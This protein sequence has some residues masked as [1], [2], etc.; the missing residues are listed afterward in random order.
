[1]PSRNRQ[2]IGNQ[3]TPMRRQVPLL[4]L[5]FLHILHLHIPLLA[6]SPTYSTPTTTYIPQ[7]NTASDPLPTTFSL[8][9]NTHTPFQYS[10]LTLPSLTLP[11]ITI[12]NFSSLFSLPS[13]TV[14]SLT[15]PTFSAIALPTNDA[16]GGGV[17]GAGGGG[18]D[19]AGSGDNF[20]GDSATA[21]AAVATAGQNI[22]QASGAERLGG[23][24]PWKGM[25]IGLVG[26]VVGMGRVWI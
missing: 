8:S 1:M 25:L 2:R 17:R 7:Q 4:I 3:A 5:S 11:S 18:G 16:A 10:S 6:I 23:G 26:F 20:I 22:G 13:I 19:V 24:I 9:S 12:P 15:V 14:P 21:T